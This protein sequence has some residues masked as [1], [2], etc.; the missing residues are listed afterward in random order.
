MAVDRKPTHEVQLVE[1]PETLRV[2]QPLAPP[3][4]DLLKRGAYQRR[5]LFGRYWSAH[6]A[7]ILARSAQRRPCAAARPAAVSGR[8]VQSSL[9]R[10]PRRTNAHPPPASIPPI[11]T[12]ITTAPTPASLPRLVC[13]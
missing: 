12:T 5:E 7:L 6:V 8:L 3:L 1:A 4:L 10:W 13:T 2:E 11:I 9:R